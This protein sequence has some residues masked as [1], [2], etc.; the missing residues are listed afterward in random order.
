MPNKSD[1]A[2]IDEII[3]SIVDCLAQ[4]FPGFH[5][6][7]NERAEKISIQVQKFN[8]E[9]Y[10]WIDVT[11][12]A[13]GYWTFTATTWDGD[14]ICCISKDRSFLDGS[15]EAARIATEHIVELTRRGDGVELLR[16]AN[17][18]VKPLGMTFEWMEM[19]RHTI[20][21]EY[22]LGSNNIEIELGLTDV[23]GIW[24]CKV[25]IVYN[26]YVEADAHGRENNRCLFGSARCGDPLKALDAA[27]VQSAAMAG[28][29]QKD[30][31]RALDR[32]S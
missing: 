14:D 23:P 6:S 7:L 29:I 25:F 32:N 11:P 4:E 16:V 20:I 30:F 8:D 19:P 24:E 28:V 17:A 12:P 1:K 5:F 18:K 3:S 21:G 26:F 22:C 9:A 27:M 13:E 15:M 31:S 2:L 10:F